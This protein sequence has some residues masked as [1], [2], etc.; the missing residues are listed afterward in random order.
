MVTLL[1]WCIYV[2]SRCINTSEFAISC[3]VVLFSAINIAVANI[4]LRLLITLTI[5]NFMTNPHLR[6]VLV[7]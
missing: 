2:L 7:W 6:P 3:V 1:F 4:Y 5:M